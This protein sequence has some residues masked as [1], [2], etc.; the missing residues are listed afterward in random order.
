MRVLL[1]NTTPD[2]APRLARA[3]VEQG[4]A[5]CVNI[6]PAV[7]SVYRWKGEVTHDTEATLLIKVAAERVEAVR[8]AI[9]ELHPY[10]VPEVVVLSVDADRSHRPYVEWVR[11]ESGRV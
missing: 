1:C 4:L 3:L 9:I 11:A 2:D 10:E 5:A 7:T 6:I 8:D